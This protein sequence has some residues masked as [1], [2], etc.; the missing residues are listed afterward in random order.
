MAT[1]P[2]KGQKFFV[3]LDSL[4]TP[5]VDPYAEVGKGTKGTKPVESP[6]EPSSVNT[7]TEDAFTLVDTDDEYRIWKSM[8][9]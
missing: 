7:H 5:K 1:G 2:I 9:S 6:P 4:L 8:I 3:E